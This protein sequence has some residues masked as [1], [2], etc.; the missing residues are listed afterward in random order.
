MSS[1]EPRLTPGGAPGWDPYEVWCTRVRKNQVEI[2]ST[3]SW[4]A[5]TAQPAAIVS[6]DTRGA[7]RVAARSKRT[8]G[9]GLAALALV[10]AVILGLNRAIVGLSG[11]D[12]I[13]RVF[14]VMTPAARAVYVLLGGAAVYCAVAT[15]VLG[16]RRVR[17][18]T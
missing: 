13:A 11:V 17:N 7:G 15:V 6:S 4:R 14:G 3:R 8:L 16:R 2:P 18:L 10:L 1:R 5:E 9:V 12:F